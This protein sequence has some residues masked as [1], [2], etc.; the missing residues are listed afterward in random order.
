[1]DN[2]TNFGQVCH[3]GKT[4]VEMQCLFCVLHNASLNFDILWFVFA[5]YSECRSQISAVSY[6]ISFIICSIPM[7]NFGVY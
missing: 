3:S 2:I 4:I 7:F 5:V 6:E 1:M